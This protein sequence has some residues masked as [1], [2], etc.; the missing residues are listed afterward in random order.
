MQGVSHKK[1]QPSLDPESSFS[2][3]I[4]ESKGLHCT[5]GED[6]RENVVFCLSWEHE[7]PPVI[8]VLVC[9]T[10]RVLLEWD[11]SSTNKVMK[12]EMTRSPDGLGPLM[13]SSPRELHS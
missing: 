3:K 1:V 10:K 9:D 12:I 11:F 8:N 7:T 13:T 5:G 2:K 4:E 6:G